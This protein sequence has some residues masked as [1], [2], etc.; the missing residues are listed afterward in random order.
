MDLFNLLACGVPNFGPFETAL[1]LVFVAI[2]SVVQFVL[3]NGT[4]LV[5]GAMAAFIGKCVYDNAQ[6]RQVEVVE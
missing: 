4:V 6:V 5:L 2:G 3:E 1:L